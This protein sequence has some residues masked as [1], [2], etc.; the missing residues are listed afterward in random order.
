MGKKLYVDLKVLLI[1]VQRTWFAYAYATLSTLYIPIIL[2][3]I[4]N[5]INIIPTFVDFRRIQVF[6]SSKYVHALN[7]YKYLSNG[8]SSTYGKML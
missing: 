8:K 3:I 4:C 2:G 5:M 6:F 1:W 7:F